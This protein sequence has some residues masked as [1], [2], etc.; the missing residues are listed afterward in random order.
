MDGED[1]SPGSDSGAS[2]EGVDTDDDNR[3]SLVSSQ[4]IITHPPTHRR[5]H[6]TRRNRPLIVDEQGDPPEGVVGVAGGVVDTDALD[7]EGAG[8]EE[9]DDLQDLRYYACIMCLQ[10]PCII[11]AI[12]E[13]P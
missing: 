2:V 1:D 10:R 7:R 5:A 4:H 8:P 13:G 9:E 12:F 3:V 6:Q 11:I